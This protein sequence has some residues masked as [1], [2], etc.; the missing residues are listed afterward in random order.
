[1]TGQADGHTPA[2]PGEIGRGP[3]GRVAVTGHWL[4]VI[5]GCFLLTSSPGL[6]A[7]LLLETTPGSLP[8][9]AVLLLPVP[10]ALSATLWA[11]RRRSRD[12]DA[13]PWPSFRRGLG[14]TWRDSLRV[15]APVLGALTVLGWT[16]LNI[17]AAGT[18]QGYAWL[19]LGI[20]A[21]ILVVG[22]QALVIATF[23]TFRYRDLWRLAAFHVFRK[24]LVTLSVVAAGVC[25]GALLWFTNEAVLLLATPTLARLLLL[26]EEPMLR[27][28]EHD[29]VQDA[30]RQLPT[31]PPSA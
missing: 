10:V 22:V 15:A 29:F 12:R 3:L 11:W 18:P 2:V 30:N 27:S 16:V 28:V 25:A 7:A 21:G 26:Y 8:V 20:G 13:A 4:L 6:A 19:L 17:G 23:F 5:T 31:T 9:L 14:L 1:M 24:P